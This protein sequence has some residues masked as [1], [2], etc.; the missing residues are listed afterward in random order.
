MPY[1]FNCKFSRSV[2]IARPW[3]S[4]D[5]RIVRLMF[6]EASLDLARLWGAL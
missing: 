3:P 4:P 1:C 2:A 6:M 5:G